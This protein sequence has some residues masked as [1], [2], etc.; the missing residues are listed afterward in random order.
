MAL[1]HTTSYKMQILINHY[2]TQELELDVQNHVMY[3]GIQPQNLYLFK[4]KLSTVTSVLLV[5]TNDFSPISLVKDTMS[6]HGLCFLTFFS[7]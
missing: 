5:L 3:L 1:F 6:V 4:A 7:L 2:A